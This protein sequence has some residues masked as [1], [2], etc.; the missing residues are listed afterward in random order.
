MT[1]LLCWWLFCH[2]APEV[3]K[4]YLNSK[5]VAVVHLHR[6][7]RLNSCTFRNVSTHGFETLGKQ[8]TVHVQGVPKSLVTVS[9]P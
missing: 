1:L 6:K 3:H 2:S 4:L 5:G 7:H 9:C 8:Q